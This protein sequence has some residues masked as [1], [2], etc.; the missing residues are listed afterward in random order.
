MGH[1][2][3]S[4]RLLRKQPFTSTLSLSDIAYSKGQVKRVLKRYD[5]LE[6]LQSNKYELGQTKYG[7]AKF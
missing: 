3:G 2:V 4:S 1:L 7:S 5:N 6:C